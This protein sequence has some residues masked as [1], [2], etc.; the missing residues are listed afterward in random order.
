MLQLRS[1]CMFNKLPVDKP[2]EITSSEYDALTQS[3]PWPTRLADVNAGVVSGLLKRGLLNESE[4]VYA[5]TVRGNRVANRCRNRLWLKSLGS[6]SYVLYIG[7][8]SIGMFERIPSKSEELWIASDSADTSLQEFNS[9]DDAITYLINRREESKPDGWTLEGKS[10]KGFPEYSKQ[11][12]F[13]KLIIWST[14]NGAFGKIRTADKSW[15]L[16]AQNVHE[17]AS[18]LVDDYKTVLRRELKSLSDSGG[19]RVI[20]DNDPCLGLHCSTLIPAE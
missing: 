19:L 18:M 1:G 6:D 3:H 15:V 16:T 12:T 2:P 14:S 8:T 20:T 17:C 13:A 7:W 4:G 10:E 9:A 11:M 5:A